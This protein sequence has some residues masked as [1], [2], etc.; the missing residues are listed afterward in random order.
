MICKVFF[1]KNIKKLLFNDYA[2]LK[3]CVIMWLKQFKQKKTNTNF[4]GKNYK[5]E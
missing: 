2:S 3:F 4:L 5:D 1:L